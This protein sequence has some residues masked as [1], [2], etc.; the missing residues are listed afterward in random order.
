MALGADL[1]GC[2]GFLAQVLLRAE[3]PRAAFELPQGDGSRCHPPQR[4]DCAMPLCEPPL[5][6]ERLREPRARPL[7]VP[8]LKLDRAEHA[9]N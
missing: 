6:L 2:A 9:Q 7:W 3:Q 1:E 4:V 5:Q 8:V